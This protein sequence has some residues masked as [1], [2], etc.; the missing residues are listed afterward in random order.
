MLADLVDNIRIGSGYPQIF[1]T[2]ATRRGDV[3]YI[4]PMLD[5]LKTDEWRAA[6]GLPPLAQQIKNLEGRFLLPVLISPRLSGQPSSLKGPTDVSALGI[7]NSDE[8]L[9]VETK[10]VN[11]NVRAFTREFKPAVGVSLGKD[12]FTIIEDGIEQETSFFSTDSAPFDMVLLL[13]FSGSTQEKRSLIKKAAKRFV[14]VARPDDRV[15][16]IAFADDQRILSELTK[17][18]N[19]LYDSIDKIKNEGGSAVWDSLK[20]AYE[21]IFGSKT[22][23]RRTAVV[24]MTDGFDNSS[25]STYADLM[26]VVRRGDTTVFPVCVKFSGSDES[27][28][29]RWGRMSATAEASLA[30]LADVSGGQFYKADD[31]KDLNGIYEQVVND[32]GRIYSLGYESKNE[33]R[34]GGWRTITV[35][36]KTHPEL[37]GRTRHGYYAK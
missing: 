26:E 29:T 16:V 24:F 12:D 28:K 36:I 30:M 11:L 14:E 18:K 17:D 20:F 33:K 9:K 7:E 10:I 15:A 6:Y 32:I 4:Y 35:K 31:L 13:D 34:D 2:Q 22:P 25:R 21:R 1:G 23:G 37:L 27:T 3:I 8:T 19:V 5:D